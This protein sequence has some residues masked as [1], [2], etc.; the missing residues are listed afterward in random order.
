M[1]TRVP[2][3]PPTYPYLLSSNLSGYISKNLKAGSQRVICTLMF[4]SALFTTAKRLKATN[5]R[6]QMNGYIKCGIYIEEVFLP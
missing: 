5:V 3:S 6:C 2:I 4:I 1:C